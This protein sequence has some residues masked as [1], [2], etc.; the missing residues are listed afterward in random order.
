MDFIMLYFNI[1]V[2]KIK[3]VTHPFD[4]AMRCCKEYQMLETWVAEKS[5]H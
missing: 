1:S 4:D 3:Q 5:Y 2:A